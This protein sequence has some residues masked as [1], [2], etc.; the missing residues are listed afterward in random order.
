MYDYS[1]AVLKSDSIMGADLAESLQNAVKLLEDIPPEQ[2]DWHPNSDDQVL[3]LVHPSLWPLVYGR[4]RVLRDRT[5]GLDDALTECGLGKVL[6]PPKDEET[7]RFKM[8]G[9]FCERSISVLSN[10]FQ[11]LPCDVDVDPATGRAKIMSY[12]NNLH[13]KEHAALYPIIETFI[14]KSLPAWDIIYR[15]EKDFAV[16]RLTVTEVGPECSCPEF[17]SASK[18]GECKPWNRPLGPED[19]DSDEEPEDGGS[20]SDN[21]MREDDYYN[22]DRRKGR[23]DAW[24]ASTHSAKLPDADPSAED[25]VNINDSDIKTNGFF[26]GTKQVQV[27]VKLANIHLTPD[28]PSY[29]GGSWHTE[30]QLN[31]HIVSTA[32]YYYDSDNITDCTLSF[33]T[34]A[35]AEDLEAE[36]TYEQNEDFAI[37]RTF[38]IQM[39]GYTLQ[40]IGSVHTK[41]GRAIFFPNLVQHRVSPFKLA[42]PTKPGHRKILALFLVDPAIPI[43]STSNVPPQQEHWWPPQTGLPLEIS[44]KQP[45]RAP[46]PI[47]LEEAKQLRLRLMKERASLQDQERRDLESV[48]WNFCEH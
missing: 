5:I 30:G 28:K 37:D 35:N 45:K 1:I 24:F 11:W 41:P 3:D 40:D 42:D 7:I 38:A 8:P 10:K 20:E 32:L 23:D 39:D 31:E 36:L 12:I 17:C 18:Y 9:S 14:E 16:Q 26:D 6:R 15:W 33:R 19:E 13:P 25:Y 2:K 27:I 44:E 21:D 43:I 29:P 48:E 34:C 22:D 46:W 4:S 47:G